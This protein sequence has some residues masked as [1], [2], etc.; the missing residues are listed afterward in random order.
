[1]VTDPLTDIL[2]ESD[3]VSIWPG[4]RDND[5]DEMHDGFAWLGI[6]MHNIFML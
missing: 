5:V 2:C 1:M 4:D 3:V 6:R